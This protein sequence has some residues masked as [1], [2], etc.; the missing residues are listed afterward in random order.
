MNEPT[1]LALLNAL[2]DGALKEAINSAIFKRGQPRAAGATCGPA[3]QALATLACGLGGGR[4][5]AREAG[6]LP[7]RAD[8]LQLTHVR[9]IPDPLV[10]D[11]VG[12][13]A[14]LVEPHFHPRRRAV[15][16]SYFCDARQVPR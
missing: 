13:R 2:S 8:V 1:Q 10:L 14:E 3:K 4:D 16:S 7:L 11:R 15:V 5:R 9:D 12:K 6:L